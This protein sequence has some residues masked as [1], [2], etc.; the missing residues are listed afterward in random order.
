MIQFLYH[1]LPRL[2]V[3]YTVL[4]LPVLVR[5]LS[6]IAFINNTPEG[7][8]LPFNTMTAFLI[9]IAGRVD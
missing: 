8:P 2:F 6:A 7:Q 1:G 4:H 3:L 5:R 9:Q